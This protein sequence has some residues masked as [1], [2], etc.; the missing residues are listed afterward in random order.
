MPA[1]VTISDPTMTLDS[2][3]FERQIAQFC[4]NNGITTQTQW[5]AAIAAI[6]AGQQTLAIQAILRS[7]KC[8]VP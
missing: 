3:E 6:T 7:M 2:L 5:L 4:K 8:S 1:Q